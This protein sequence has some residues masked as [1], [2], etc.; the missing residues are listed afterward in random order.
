VPAVCEKGVWGPPGY[1]ANQVRFVFVGA[2]LRV[3]GQGLNGILADEVGLG[4][5][6]QTVA[7]L[8]YLAC[9][10]GVW[11]PHLVVVPTRCV[12]FC[13]WCRES[14]VHAVFGCRYV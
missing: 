6:I 9:E 2:G 3:V 14:C 5:T 4:K 12:L 11:G 10:E 8:A 1:G 13:W 7:L